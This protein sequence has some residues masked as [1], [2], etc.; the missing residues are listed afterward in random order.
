MKDAPTSDASAI[1]GKMKK[2]VS[3]WYCKKRVLLA[4]VIIICFGSS[5]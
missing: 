4:G 3:V 2:R 1:S 5:A